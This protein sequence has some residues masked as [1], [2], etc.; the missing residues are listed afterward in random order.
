MPIEYDYENW[1]EPSNAKRVWRL[2]AGTVAIIVFW[3]A[4]ITVFVF[5]IVM[6]LAALSQKK[7]QGL[8][9]FL[10]AVFVVVLVSSIR[11]LGQITMALML[12]RR[13]R[14]AVMVVEDDASEGLVRNF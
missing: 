9:I 3:L 8:M 14:M 1:E 13:C 6:V 5:G 10:S 11:L 7:E 4:V 12:W 2:I